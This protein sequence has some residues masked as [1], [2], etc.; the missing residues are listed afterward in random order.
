MVD[1]RGVVVAAAVGVG[2]SIVGIVHFLEFAG[3][4]G[5]FGGVGGYAV[6]VGA[7]GSSVGS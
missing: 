4:F 5:A 3:A 1:S 2:K 7:E 6:G